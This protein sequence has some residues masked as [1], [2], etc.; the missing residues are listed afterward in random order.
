MQIETIAII[1]AG[2]LGRHFACLSLLG[3]YRTILEDVSSNAVDRAITAIREGLA[4]DAVPLADLGAKL[5][6]AN[7]VEQALRGADLIIE[8][9]ADEL[10]MKLELFTIFDKFAQPG[11]IFASTTNSI[12]ISDLADM[13][14]CPERC[15][16]MQLTSA[17]LQ[18]VSSRYTSQQ[19]L[20]GCS[21][22]ARRMRLAVDTI[23]E[24]R[25]SKE[26]TVAVAAKPAGL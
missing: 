17:R 20:D 8:T 1:G 3:G 18:L 25:V 13:T 16:G 2:E 15:I 23:N 22:V 7:S 12:R 10:E 4:A 6:S 24:D 9:V 14:F 21:E 11:A 19:T 26:Q 5:A